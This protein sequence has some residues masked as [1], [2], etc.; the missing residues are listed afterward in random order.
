MPLSTYSSDLSVSLSVTPV[1]PAREQTPSH[2]APSL[3]SLVLA[4][5]V[6]RSALQVAA[7]GAGSSR[8]QDRRRSGRRGACWMAGRHQGAGLKWLLRASRNTGRR[9]R[10]KNTPEPRNP[11]RTAQS[12]ARRTVIGDPDT[13]SRNAGR[14]SQRGRRALPG[15]SKTALG[16]LRNAQGGA[17]CTIMLRTLPF[18]VNCGVHRKVIRF[19]LM[20]CSQRGYQ[21]TDSSLA[22]TGGGRNCS[23]HATARPFC[24]AGVQLTARSDVSIS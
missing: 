18:A 9:R 4:C 10:P 22:V 6:P 1:G 15:R 20:R 7:G 8:E 3:F 23:S 24:A 19:E 16:P 11:D 2:H 12:E 21:R 17:L 5:G 13:K 14:R